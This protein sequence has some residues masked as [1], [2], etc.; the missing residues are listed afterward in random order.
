MRVRVVRVEAEHLVEGGL[1]CVVLLVTHLLQPG[2]DQ[3][4]HV[5][6]TVGRRA[7]PSAAVAVAVTSTVVVG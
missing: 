3:R 7:G 4:V 5:T 6:S 1:G 2:G